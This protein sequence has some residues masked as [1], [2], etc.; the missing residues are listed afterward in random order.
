MAALLPGA[1]FPRPRPP[2]VED[3]KPVGR[4]KASRP[5]ATAKAPVAFLKARAGV[6]VSRPKI[7][8][9]LPKALE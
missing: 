6:P 4:S 2:V 3:G 1:G 7:D 9:L 8:A 5:E